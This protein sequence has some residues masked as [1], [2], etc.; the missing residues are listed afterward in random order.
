LAMCYI[1]HLI[2]THEK[3]SFTTNDFLMLSVVIFLFFLP[4]G[5]AW[6]SH[7][8]SIAVKCFLIFICIELIFKKIKTESNFTL[9]PAILALGVNFL[10]S[11]L[12]FVR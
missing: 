5:Y 10:V 8:R 12:H 11:L 1:G 4:K 6:A 7:F 9:T 2:S 3:I